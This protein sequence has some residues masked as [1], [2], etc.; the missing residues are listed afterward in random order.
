MSLS[1]QLLYR[2]GAVIL[3]LISILILFCETALVF[4]TENNKALVFYRV[5][6]ILFTII[7]FFILQIIE[8]STNVGGVT[9]FIILVLGYILFCS[10][11]ALFE[12]D[13][14]AGFEIYPYHTHPLTMMFNSKTC[15]TIA[16]NNFNDFIITSLIYY[17]FW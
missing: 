3:G 15:G 8:K 6:I 10:C 9:F 17:L 4:S 13:L 14:G 1:K 12:I 7:I 5:I 16:V 11:F 2:T